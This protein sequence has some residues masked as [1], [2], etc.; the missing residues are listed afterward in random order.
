M[1]PEQEASAYDEEQ[2]S[3]GLHA[4][5]VPAAPEE[6]LIGWAPSADKAYVKLRRKLKNIGIRVE[7]LT[8]KT[9]DHEAPPCFKLV[10]VSFKEWLEAASL[11]DLPYRFS[12]PGEVNYCRDCLPA[13][14]AVAHAANACLFPQT[15]FEKVRTFDEKELVGM[16]RSRQVAPDGYLLYNRLTV[17][18]EA[19]K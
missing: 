7:H 8:T 6:P 17:D 19:L 4:G 2:E 9:D 12:M 15:T 13:F 14:K 1:A 11:T 5:S 10:G 18:E 3:E 16:S